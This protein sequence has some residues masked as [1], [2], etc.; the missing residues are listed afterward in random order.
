[1][2][3]LRR[4]TCCCA[5]AGITHAPAAAFSSAIHAFSAKYGVTTLGVKATAAGSAASSGKKRG[6]ATFARARPVLQSS[7]ASAPLAAAAAAR[8]AVRAS[9]RP[10]AFRVQL[11]AARPLASLLRRTLK[12]R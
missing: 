7:Q 2:L 6:L 8:S 12:L 9:V 3:S 10:L 1:M 11:S 5:G 4:V